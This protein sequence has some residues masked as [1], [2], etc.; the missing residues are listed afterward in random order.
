LNGSRPKAAA[1]DAAM[2]RIA[3]EGVGYARTTQR[4]WARDTDPCGR[5]RRR[6][7]CEE[8]ADCEGDRKAQSRTGPKPWAVS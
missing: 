6:T 7:G 1:A 4:V 5:T 3:A 8:A 2:K